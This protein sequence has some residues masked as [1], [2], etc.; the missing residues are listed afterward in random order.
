[1]KKK[2]FFDPTSTFFGKMTE[3]GAKLLRSIPYKQIMVLVSNFHK[4]FQL[5][6]IIH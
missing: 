3:K 1:M 6:I 4:I 2:V 5:L